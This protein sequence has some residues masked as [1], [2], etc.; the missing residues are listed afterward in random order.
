MKHSHHVT[1]YLKPFVNL[2]HDNWDSSL[3]AMFSYNTSYHEETKISPYELIFGHRPRS[4]STLSEPRQGTTQRNS[5]RISRGLNK[6]IKDRLSYFK[7][8]AKENLRKAKESSNQ[9]YDK[10]IKLLILDPRDFVYV[11]HDTRKDSKKLID[12]YDGLFEVIRQIS[13][14]NYEIKRGRRNQTLHINKL[15][16]A[17][18]PLQDNTGD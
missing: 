6:K 4:S 16:R 5:R 11:L 2:Q 7:K 17:Y 14:V 8:Y 9:C 10:R 18:F 1:E 13:D 15:K 3:G 12:Q